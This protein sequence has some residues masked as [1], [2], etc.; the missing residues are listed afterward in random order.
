MLSNSKINID[1]IIHIA[2]IH[3][4][5]SSFHSEYNL[6]FQEFYKKLTELK[7][8]NPNTIVCL[9]GDLLHSKDE[10]KP[11]TI[12]QTWNFL[13]N[14]ADIFPLIIIAGNHDTIEQND[15]KIDSIMAILK[16]R[17][18]SNIH[19]LIKSGVYIYNNLAF[20]VSSIIDHKIIH[21]DE[22]NKLLGDLL[23]ASTPCDKKYIKIALYHG[24]ISTPLN[25]VGYRL[26]GNKTLEDF[27]DYDYILLGDVHK[28]QYL[29]D[30]KTVAYA[31]S[32]ISQNFSESDQYH[33]YIQWDITSGASKYIILPN[34]H[35]Y[36]TMKSSTDKLSFE[37]G[38]LRIECS[39][40]NEKQ[41]IIDKFR[42]CYPN[43]ILSWKTN[44]K[45][46]IVMNKIN[47]DIKMDELINK[48]LKTKL[49]IPHEKIDKIITTLHKLTSKTVT[50]IE[51]VKS[52]W[53]ILWLSFDYM[54][55]YG[56]NNI[57]DFTKYPTNDLIGIFGDNAVGKSSIIDIIT[58]MLFSQSARDESSTTP[59]DIINSNQNKAWG[60][61]VIESCGIKYLIK[62][63]CKKDNKKENT[64][65]IRQT[66]ELYKLLEKHGGNFKLFDK[67]YKLYSLI[68]KDRFSTSKIL[69]NIIG[70][71]ENF[72]ATSIIL[73]GNNK[74]IKTMNN[75]D[76]KD[77]L[78][79]ILDIAYFSNIDETVKTQYK[80]L[81]QQLSI[82]NKTIDN[83]LNNK[84]INSIDEQNKNLIKTIELLEKENDTNIELYNSILKDITDLSTQIKYVINNTN[85][86]EIIDNLAKW[87]HELNL[88]Q[89][90][91]FDI[92][93][94][95]K[96]INERAKYTITNNIND[97]HLLN[98]LNKLTA[99]H[100]NIISNIE[101]NQKK[102]NNITN[103]ILLLDKLPNKDNIIKNNEIYQSNKKL[104]QTTIYDNIQQLNEK[105]NKL[106]LLINRQGID[107]QINE[108]L[109]VN[110]NIV[111]QKTKIISD[112][113]KLKQIK[114]ISL[115]KIID[116]MNGCA[117]QQNLVEHCIKLK[118]SIN[119][120]F[121]NNR[122]IQNY[123]K[124]NTYIE[125]EKRLYKLHEQKKQNEIIKIEINRIDNE[126]NKLQIRLKLII[127]QSDNMNEFNEL[128]F[129]INQNIVYENEI[130]KLRNKI[131]ELEL[132]KLNNIVVIDKVKQQICTIHQNKINMDKVK[133]LDDEIEELNRQ[134]EIKINAEKLE[135]QIASNEKELL[136]IRENKTTIENNKK[137]NNEISKLRYELDDKKIMETKTSIIKLRTELD[138][139]IQLIKKIEIIQKEK[140]LI[141]RDY[142][143][144]DILSKITGS[145]GLQLYLLNEYMDKIST[146]IN[147]ILSQFIDKTIIFKLVNNKTIE[148]NVISNQKI[149]NTLSGMESFMLDLAFR[150]IIRDISVIPK[151]NIMFIDESISVFDKN[152]V[153]AI[154]DFF[155]FLRQYYGQV[156]L[157]THMKQV[158]GYIEN[159]IDVEKHNGYSCITNYII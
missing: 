83:L 146:R 142:E 61:I 13:K 76:K 4:R 12:V 122:I 79:E 111:K 129:Q 108:Y 3:I 20:A 52:D 66:M 153:A 63:T 14:V 125:Y 104:E 58:Y 82:C 6:V 27:G 119:L 46:N 148:I 42:E 18:I 57:I 124:L 143:L 128:N 107:T 120:L 59:K 90:I 56:A 41:K 24:Q 54:Y 89:H 114:R 126:I 48:Y 92:E 7:Q 77:F 98:E 138:N 130:S 22:C 51:Y 26:K 35:A 135:Q 74:T 109:T 85:E 115:L 9:C 155:T 87:R 10:L 28:F 62:R 145:D 110:T 68:E 21:L 158:K 37:S 101:I 91:I 81:K 106:A 95:N 102:I 152:R 149:I 8:T 73:Q 64:Y 25:S 40:I 141:E 116:E 23:C 118:E 139:N 150:I 147:E 134:R 30:K 144:Y 151:S 65:Q 47:G 84:T 67:E 32:M 11:D 136:F 15:D 69:T 78:C 105:K 112:Y 39:N 96:K 99:Q 103:N 70:T 49:N 2:D 137:I 94:Y 50:N 43:I 53:K 117:S 16:D 140:D 31:S 34:A 133:I 121:A 97:S 1:T 71:Y 93:L 75:K 45:N 113:K 154:D 80:T 123:N 159:Y 157:I 36:H 5:L 72:I 19:Y 33:G 100:T 38:Y 60:S 132:A 88:K 44:V 127:E 131:T 86:Q 17:P 29:N 156:Y 55:G